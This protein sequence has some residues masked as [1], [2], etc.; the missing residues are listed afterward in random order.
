[1]KPEAWNKERAE[2]FQNPDTVSAYQYRAPYPVETFQILSGLIADSPRTVLDAGCGRGEIARNLINLVDRVDAVDFSLPMIESGKKLAHGNHPY[3]NWICGKVEDAPLNPSYSL[4]TA[5]HSLH[6]LDWEVVMP[7]FAKML[8]PNGYLAIVGNVFSPPAWEEGLQ[9]LRVKYGGD[10]PPPK[11]FDLGKELEEAD[12]FKRK[13]ERETASVIY[14]NSRDAYVEHFHSR[15]DMARARIG[16]E[17]ATGFDNDLRELLAE[18]VEGDMVEVTLHARI[19]WG[20]P[21][22]S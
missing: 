18:Y 10:V 11:P 21:L 13:G 3:L 14:S 16:E 6:W 15:S 8:I 5:G 12:L 17:A 20:K 9:K 4:I 7:R 19:T 1:L 2:S 22:C